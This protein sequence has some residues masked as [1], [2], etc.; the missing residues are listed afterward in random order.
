[1]RSYLFPLMNRYFINSKSRLQTCGYRR[2]LAARKH[3]IHF[4]FFFFI[5]IIQLFPIDN[6]KN[7]ARVQG[8]SREDEVGDTGKHLCAEV[9]WLCIFIFVNTYTHYCLCTKRLWYTIFGKK[10]KK[11]LNRNCVRFCWFSYEL[12][13][14]WDCDSSF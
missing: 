5:V 3:T 14:Y 1:M 6:F 9:N 13:Y 7:F 11:S 12:Q 2:H 4:F 10:E 8:G